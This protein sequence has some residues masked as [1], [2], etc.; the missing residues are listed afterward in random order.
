MQTGGRDEAVTISANIKGWCGV[1]RDS[2]FGYKMAVQIPRVD[3]SARFLVCYLK[4]I[5]LSFFLRVIRDLLG[6]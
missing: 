3:Q 2:D 5:I 6:C 4:I 1:L